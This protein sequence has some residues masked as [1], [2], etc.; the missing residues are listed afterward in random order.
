LGLRKW[1]YEYESFSI[2]KYIF[3]FTWFN[4]YYPL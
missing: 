2:T 4:W 3:R 1:S